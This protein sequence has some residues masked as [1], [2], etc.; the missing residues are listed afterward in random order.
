MMNGSSR[1][2]LWWGG[3]GG[4]VTNR[5]NKGYQR[6][7]AVESIRTMAHALVY[8]FLTAQLQVI[9]IFIG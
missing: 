2:D 4:G 5:D 3:D 7:R 1:G 8:S 9:F 6:E